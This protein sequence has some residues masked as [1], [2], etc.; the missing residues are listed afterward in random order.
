MKKIFALILA[1]AMLLC[2]VSASAASLGSPFTFDLTL[3]RTYFET[4]Y[5]ASVSSTNTISWIQSGN[6][7]T[8]TAPELSDV[9]LYTNSAGKVTH[10]VSILTGPT[11]DMTYE[12]GTKLGYS[13][14]LMAMSALMAETGDVNA[15]QAG[16]ATIED[17]YNVILACL[18]ESEG[19]T[20]LEMSA[21]ASSTGKLMGYPAN[22]FYRIDISNLLNPQ[23]YIEFTLA[24]TGSTF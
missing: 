2:T 23:Y 19:K 10:M 17:D 9:I 13:S 8:I 12:A 18:N 6:T 14:S 16:A 15:L 21:G 7:V 22:T 20:N 11:S 5:N 4:F 24:P 3:F 1:L